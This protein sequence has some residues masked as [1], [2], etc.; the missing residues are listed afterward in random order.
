MEVGFMVLIVETS[1]MPSP[2]RAFQ[3]KIKEAG[4]RVGL[5]GYA[6]ITFRLAALWYFKKNSF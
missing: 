1:F 5:E 3:R 4:V 6:P 2:K